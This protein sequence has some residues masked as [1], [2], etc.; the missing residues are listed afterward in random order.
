MEKVSATHFLRFWAVLG[1]FALV[2]IWFLPWRFQTNDD[3]L[4]MWLVSGAY[5]GTPESYAV[6]IHPILSWIFSELYTALPDVPWYPL[7]WF[8]VLYLSYL[9]IVI[10]LTLTESAS[11]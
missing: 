10:S 9:G 1:L 7:T 6:F 11:N 8:G 3:E 5:T 4:M 2:L